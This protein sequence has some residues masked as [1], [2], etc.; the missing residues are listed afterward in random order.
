MAHARPGNGPGLFWRFARGTSQL[1]GRPATFAAVTLVV[2]A[3]ALGGPAFGYSESWQLAINTLT[4]IVTF[5]MVFLIQATQNREAEAI[6]LKLD[7][8]IV[9]LKG[10]RNE[11][12]DSENLTEEEQLKLHR[13][14]LAMAERART[15]IGAEL[16][17]LEAK[18]ERR[19]RRR[20]TAAGKPATRS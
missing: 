1:A 16:D 5:L 20:R 19:G 11:L 14:Y 2:A 15:S 8:L 3:W 17:Q 4:T 10:A 9:S 13:R 6:Q 7:E 12:L 18:R